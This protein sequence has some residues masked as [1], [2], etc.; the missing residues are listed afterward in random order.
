MTV[1]PKRMDTTIHF[2]TTSELKD[3]VQKRAEEKHLSPSAFLNQLLHRHLLDDPY[4]E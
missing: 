3:A 2:R 1:L 4:N